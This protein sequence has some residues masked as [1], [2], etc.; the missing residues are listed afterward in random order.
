[1]AK[2][3]RTVRGSHQAYNIGAR[4]LLEAGNR[5]EFLLLIYALEPL[6]TRMG[7]LATTHDEGQR[8]R[9]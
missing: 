3:D 1:M 8:D 9:A 5:L 4:L 7:T 2:D 6:S